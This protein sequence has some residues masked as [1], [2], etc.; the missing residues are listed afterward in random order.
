MGLRINQNISALTAARTLQARQKALSKSLE[1]L[2]TGQQINSGADNPS[3]L[4]ISENL[5]VQGDSLERNIQG[6]QRKINE[7]RTEDAK[8]GEAFDQLRS[9]R[10]RALEAVNTGGTDAT[11]R[12]ANQTSAQSSV[13]SVSKVLKGIDTTDEGVD[14]SSLSGISSDLEKIDIST[15]SGAQKA[16]DTVDAAIEKLSTYRGEVGA[17]QSNNLEAGVQRQGVELENLRSSESAIRDTDFADTTVEFV[18]NRVLFQANAAV[19][20]KAN[21]TAKSGL[22]ILNSVGNGPST[23]GPRNLL[24]I[25]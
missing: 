16:L 18:K 12:A 2:S 13:S 23:P 25:A 17:H 21:K 5:R 6:D 15:P 14:S 22:Q 3:G 24:G 4:I 1:R 19:L 11:A 20:S 9:V 10:N 8:L 7:L